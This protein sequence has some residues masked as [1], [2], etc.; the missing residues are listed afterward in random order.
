ME[1]HTP[2][3]TIT[4]QTPRPLDAS[5]AGLD[6]LLAEDQPVNQ[7]LVCAVMERLGHRLTIANNGVECVRAM[8]NGRYDL[9]LMDIQMPEMDGML[10]TKVIRAAD[11]PWR[12]IPI[13]A[14]TA[15]AMENH[16]LAYLAAGMDGFVAKPFKIDTLVAEM[17]RVLVEARRK[18][19]TDEAPAAHAMT[20]H[21]AVPDIADPHAGLLDGALQD[22]DRLLG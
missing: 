2:D 7:K 12:S 9:I 21:K 20:E 3:D 11:E 16:R 1:R 17:T 6:V 8:R 13:V 15:H 19:G 4:S 5:G 10:A 22:L 18:G 14:L